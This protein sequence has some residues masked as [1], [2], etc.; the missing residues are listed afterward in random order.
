M[1]S[2]HWKKSSV[3]YGHKVFIIGVTVMTI[4]NSMLVVILICFVSLIIA[5]IT[6]S[7]MMIVTV[8]TTSM[9]GLYLT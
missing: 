4:V 3:G 7:I 9:I 1:T 2:T 8:T 6:I 5:V